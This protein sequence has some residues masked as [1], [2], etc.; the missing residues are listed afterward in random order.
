MVPDVD[1][2]VVVTDARPSAATTNAAN[3]ADA[4]APGWNG[5]VREDGRIEVV[6][7]RPSVR[8][9]AG[10][11][12]AAR[13]RFAPGEAWQRA[14]D[15]AGTRGIQY[16]EPTF[17]IDSNHGERDA[18]DRYCPPCEPENEPAD[19]C[20]SPIA[21]AL[22][23]PEWSVDGR[24]GANVVGAWDKFSA[25]GVLPGSGVV[26]GH[27]DTGYRRHPE[28]YP[29][30][31]GGGVFFEDGWNFINNTG[32]DPTKPDSS[33][34]FDAL[35]GGFLR[36]PGHGTKTSSVIVSPRGSQ[37]VPGA[38]RWVSGVA[39]GAA[40]IPLR[41]A[42]GVVLFPADFGELK[43]NVA[44]L[45]DAI[46]A[47]SGPNRDRVKRHA[48][49]ISISMGGL[50]GTRDLADAVEYAEENGV[51]VIAAAGNEV[52]DRRVV[53]PA[54]FESVF[55]IAA[56][57]YDSKPWR[58]SS[59][60]SHVAVTAPGES[61]WTAASRP[62]QNCLHASDGT[63]FATATTAGIAALWL[64]YPDQKHQQ[65]I[66]TLRVR[67]ALPRGFRYALGR[68]ARPVAGNP[69]GFG[70]GIVDAAALMD[71]DL[72]PLLE[73]RPAGQAPPSAWCPG[74]THSA[75]RALEG[76]FR[77]APDGRDRV[78]RLLGVR[79]VCAEPG[80]AD[81]T[82]F[83]STAD[84]TVAASFGPLI[85]IRQPSTADY[86]KARRAILSRDVS[87]RLRAALT[88]AR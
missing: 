65:A 24:H 68:A 53:F 81:E 51:I 75:F 14:H 87:A 21:G 6:P 3:V 23:N 49:V 73:E 8:P 2:F 25:S 47:A 67:E 78:A 33:G 54:A 29:R 55:A 12:V 40:L 5:N 69:T 41:V 38:P 52:P 26:I 30:V 74:P 32:F 61:V 13:T 79:D 31:G 63:S 27:P 17:T 84:G 50:P 4:I 83:W 20:H 19:N 16:V 11:R 36:N 10:A 80:L 22:A 39:P 86:E 56:S 77:D 60:G 66:Q 48:D 85:A 62:G 35:L 15:L 43:V 44:R 7:P 28:I 37:F 72:S 58:C 34:P 45:A 46:R 1:G 42:E 71:V 59:H 82:A 76:E 9:S 64:S 18:P 70:A 88:A 57:N